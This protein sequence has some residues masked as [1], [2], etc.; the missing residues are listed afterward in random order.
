M[1]K[2]IVCECANILYYEPPKERPPL[3]CPNCG[4]D[5]RHYASMK[6]DDPRVNILLE[7]YRSRISESISDVSENA[8]DKENTDIHE[9]DVKA[10]SAKSESINTESAK[11]ESTQEAHE[12]N[13]HKTESDLPD[14]GRGLEDRNSSSMSISSHLYMLRS[15]SGKYDII[16]PADG[17]VIGR[18]ALGGEELAHNGRI[19]R[20]HIKIV[21]AKRAQGVMIEDISANGT[22]VDGRRVSKNEREFVV[23]GSEITM[24][25][26]AFILEKA[27]CNS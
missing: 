27:A 9:A 7:K 23:I 18:T 10:E 11:T 25:G 15:V 12:M 6:T 20:E 14:S 3:K 24:G 22:F 19:S 26:E 17:G 13:D 8:A 1:S 4:R 21:P 16:I 5:T 2:C